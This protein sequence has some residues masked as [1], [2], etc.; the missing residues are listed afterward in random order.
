MTSR[1]RPPDYDGA[2]LTQVLPSVLAALTRTEPVLPVPAADRIVVLLI[3]GLGHH[4]LADAGGSAPFLSAMTPLAPDG[5]DAAFPSTTPTSLASFGTGLPPGA[6]GLVGAS[7]WLPEL[8]GM[9]S[10]LGWRDR[11]SPA[12]VQQEP[13]VFETAAEL[14]VAVSAVGPRAFAGSGLTAA[15]LRGPRY[16]GADSPGEIVVAVPAAVAASAPPGLVYGYFADVD[17]AGHIHGAASEQWQLDLQWTDRAIAA[18]A[19]RLPPGVLLL[20]T[21]DH[22][23]INCPD[24]ARVSIDTAPFAEGVRRIGGEPR[25]RHIY[26]DA[27][28]DAS[29]VAARWQH[30]L[31]E[32]AVVVTRET[33]VAAGLYGT[34]GY[35]MAQRIGDV[36]AIAAGDAALVSDRVDSVVSGLRGQHGGLTEE[37]R[38]VPLLAW[39]S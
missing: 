24:H 26:L 29:E 36:L 5:I 1:W 22:G 37:E 19:E 39:A 3:D 33:A 27:G 17:K 30:L 34:L 9:L 7:F 38:R 2:C 25:M 35:G 23:M 12:M 18:I 11:P 21:A 15:A 13:T 4:Q 8:D 32:A 10:P 28:V 16:L 20:V 14:G 31:G 6:H